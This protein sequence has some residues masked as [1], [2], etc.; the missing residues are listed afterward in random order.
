MDSDDLW[1]LILFAVCLVFSA[2]FSAS[3]TALVSLSKIRIRNMVDENVSRAR[4]IQKLVDDPGKM[5]SAIL[6]GNNIVNVGA[7][8]LATSLAIRHFGDVGVG[9]ATGVT[10]LLVLIFG[11]ITPKSLAAS[12]SEKISLKVAAFIS[13]FVTVTNPVS[14]LLMH[15]ANAL[16]KLM[17][18][19]INKK[20]P[21]ITEE[22]LKTI[23][24]VGHEEGVLQGEEKKMI[25]NVLEFGES[26]VTDVMTPL[27]DMTAVE[28]HSPYDKIVEVFKDKRF[29][30]VPVFEGRMDNIVGILYLKD[31]FFYDAEADNEAFN[32]TSY[33][34]EPYFTFEFKL[35]TQLFNEMRNNRIQMAIVLDEYGGTAGIIT[36]EDLVEEIVGDIHDESDEHYNEIEIIKEDEYIARGVVKIDLINEMLGVKI[37]SED[38]DSIGGYVTGLFGRLPAE[39]ELMENNNIKFIVESVN[40]NRIEKLRILT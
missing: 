27:I 3:E 20:A 14:T 33:M 12:N 40:R 21:F 17:G 30:R 29:S 11:E 16:I 9:I 38:F 28:I 10:T 8:A 37:E 22:E 32:V 23:I 19:K 34:K 5:L 1:Q 2:I 7:A 36:M 35:I 18:G 25:Q 31:L 15:L 4:T 13:F 39:G 26:K 24:N 6:V